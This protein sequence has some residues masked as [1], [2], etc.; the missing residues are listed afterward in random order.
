MDHTRLTGFLLTVLISILPLTHSAAQAP[1]YRDTPFRQDAA[2]QSVLPEGSSTARLQQ[3]RSDRNG[4]IL[5]LSTAGLL[6]PYQGRLV[7]DRH[8]RPLADM[9]LRALATW[10]DQFVYLSDQAVLS[11]AWAGTW[12]TSHG[13][14]SAGLFAPGAGF[15]ALV[16][17][18]GSLAY[19]QPDGQAWSSDLRNT[20][21]RRIIYDQNRQSYLV[22]TGDGL[23]RF[24][25]EAV[26]YQKVFSIDD[27]TDLALTGSG[28][29]LILATH[30]DYRTLDP[31]T[32]REIVAPDSL[33]PWPD[34]TCV[35]AIHGA[36]WFG[37]PRGA[38]AIRPNGRIDYYASRRWLPDDM[39]RDIAAGPDGSVLVL[40]ATGLSQIQFTRMTLAEKAAHFERITRQRHIRYGFSSRFVMTAPGDL[41]TG[42]LM[43][44]DNDGLWTAMY[45]AGELFRYGT[46][47]SGEALQNC[48]E[49]FRALERLETITPMEGFPARAIERTGYKQADTERWRPANNHLWD[50]KAT[51]SS[52]E[53]VGHFFALG[54]FA[55]MV[56]DTAMRQEAVDL[57]DRIMDHIVRNDWYLIDYDGKPT[58]WGRWNP[59][60][61]N[62]FP[63]AVGDRRLNSV[64]I[65]SFLETA[66][67]F[68]HKEIY[69]EKADELM[70]DHGYLD[71]I[72]IPITSIGHVEGVNLSDSWNHSDDELAFLSYWNLYKYAFTD[73]LKRRFR[74][75]IHG[76]WN[77][78]RPEKNPL[79]DFIFAMAGAVNYDRES[80]IWFLKEFPMDLRDW[81]VTNSHR[82]DIKKLAP[83]FRNQTTEEVLPPDERPLSKFNGNAFQLDGGNRGL[84]EYSGDIYLLPYWMGRYLGVI[85]ESE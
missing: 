7:P 85:R 18:N 54:L 64:E 36:L 77:I 37:T 75:V 44:Q 33:L 40:T 21:I 15:T 53:I 38:F 69:R 30:Q 41:S 62:Q 34:L 16:A 58:R 68:T 45:L 22:L 76:H 11:N 42:T 61:V 66:Y 26:V 19:F 23:Y 9:T 46:T 51:T 72:M 17:G 13:I 78:E 48:Y 14:P 2:V 1:F 31:A 35:R 32:F 79:W 4:N 67:H 52:D 3:V 71:N 6:Q 20:A 49:S 28:D 8:H 70:E 59:E 10:D 47:H 43:D 74:D 81:T 25:P 84:R 65:I 39:V 82:R 83:N 5:V 57:M 55:E 24:N 12:Y 73:D 50:W 29:S 60:Y 80:A 63:K 56:P 27:A